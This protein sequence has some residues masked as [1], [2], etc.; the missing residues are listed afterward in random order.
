MTRR[1][2]LVMAALLVAVFAAWYLLLWSPTNSELDE[3]GARRAAAEDR[4]EQLELRLSRLR[5]SEG[6]LV[7]L[8]ET[9]D[10]LRSAV[11]EEPELARFIL[12]ANEAASGAGVDFLDITPARPAIA[13]TAGAPSDVRLGIKVEGGYFQVLDYLERVLALPRLVVIDNISVNP[14][15]QASR[16]PRLAVDLT[17]RMFVAEGAA[18]AGASTP[19][20]TP[21]A[22]VEGT[23]LGG[24]AG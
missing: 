14:L 15:D 6:E 17:A 13:T 1:N 23:A 11:P 5:A 22:P 2:L 3:V 4:A 21:A 9:R 20:G 10:R 8:T 18:T 7:R 12:D 24:G 16:T 19:P